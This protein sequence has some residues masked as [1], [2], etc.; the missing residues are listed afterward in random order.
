MRNILFRESRAKDCQE[1]KE[2][3]R[4]VA[5]KQDEKTS[6]NWW[7]V[8]ASREE[9]WNCESALDSN[10][11]SQ[12]RTNSLSDTREFHDSETASSSSEREPCLAAIL[13]CL[14]IQG[15][16][17]V[18]QETLSNDYLLE[19]DEPLL[20]SMI[21]GIRHFLFKNWDLTIQETQSDPRVKRDENRKTRFFEQFS[22]ATASLKFSASMV[23]SQ[24]QDWSIFEISRSLS[25]V[26]L[27]QRSW[28]DKVNWR[29]NDVAYWKNFSTSM[30]T[31]T[32]KQIS[33]SAQK[34]TTDSYA[35]E[36]HIYMI[37]EH[38]RVIGSCQA[39]QALSDL[40]WYDWKDCTSQN[41]RILFSFRLSCLWTT[42]KLS[43]T[44]HR[45]HIDQMMRTRSFRVRNEVMERGAV[46]NSQKGKKS[47]LVEVAWTM[48]ER[49]P[50]H[51]SRDEKVFS[52]N[53]FEV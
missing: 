27:D 30:F 25:L 40:F 26:A 49:K 36:R 16:L 52:L 10:A 2:L 50:S 20:L 47:F 32:K 31:S 23:K 19:K 42:M 39:L 35:R 18:R 3:R 51:G 6:K 33:K 7:I 5:K 4:I 12:D 17:W 48:F 15:T 1:I 38:F 11:G 34:N 13:D 8:C 43:R 14:M 45:L 53:K 44:I 28:D 41:C 24:L 22:F 46:N 29:A 37:Y 9:S 21:H